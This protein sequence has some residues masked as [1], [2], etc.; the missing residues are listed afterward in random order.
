MILVLNNKSNLTKYEF[1][2][3]QER[4]STIKTHTKVVLCP[5][6]LNISLFNLTKIEL[7][8]QNVSATDEGAYTGEVAA[9]ELKE[10]GVK[11]CIVGHSER[12]EYQN[13]T[14][15]LV[16]SKILELL[17]NDIIP[18]L[19]IGETKEE[20]E[21]NKVEEVIRK[22]LEY[23]VNRLD[24]SQKSRLV[25]A[26]E[27]IWSIG[28]GLVPTVEEIDE[29]LSLIKNIIPNAT[30]L[31]GGSANEENINTL[32]NSKYTEGYLVGGLSLKPDKL[33][34]FIKILE[35]KE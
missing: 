14:D 7:G 28:T 13:E 17:K 25:I 18:I 31:Y 1:L 4:L 27:P 35:S 3:Y 20:R 34:Q 16:F 8:A 6:Y 33:Q 5:N 9:K 2:T 15:E 11:Y 24:D 19:C 22:E 30:L 10:N 29:V 12:R 23:A 26:Y 32:N 21:S